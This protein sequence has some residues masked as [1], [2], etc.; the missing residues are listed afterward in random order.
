MSILHEEV[1]WMY[2]LEW[3]GE[4]K[5]QVRD[6]LK[7]HLLHTSSHLYPLSQDVK[8]NR[9]TRIEPYTTRNQDLSVY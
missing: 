1:K 6:K 3:Q 8:L 2:L 4:A 5:Y 7:E 9:N